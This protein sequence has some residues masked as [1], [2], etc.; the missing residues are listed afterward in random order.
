MNKKTKIINVLYLIWTYND[1]IGGHYQSFIST[2]NSVVDSKINVHIINIGHKPALSLEKCKYK[3]NYIKVT[4]ETFPIIKKR[5]KKYSTSNNIDIIHS[6]DYH[7]Y[8]FTSTTNCKNIVTYPGGSNY[9]FFPKADNILMFS[10][11]NY[12]YFSQ[13]KKYTN[14]F[15]FL[16]QNRVNEVEQD[17]KKIEEL[18][19]KYKP[20][21]IKI[22]KIARIGP[23]YEHSIL[24]AIDFSNT[25]SS[26]N[27]E[28]T[29]YIIGFIENINTKITIQRKIQNSKNKNIHLIDNIRYTNNAN[30]LIDLC[31]LILATGRGIMEGMALKKVVLAPIDKGYDH[32]LVNNENIDILEYYNFSERS[33]LSSTDV[34]RHSQQLDNLLVNN[35]HLNEYQ[36]WARDTFENRYSTLNITEKL[37]KIYDSISP[38]NKKLKFDYK[39]NYQ[40]IK[41]LVLNKLKNLG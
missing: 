9:K 21:G 26:K 27:I 29:L 30:S 20:N 35:A 3:V 7:S 24:S 8:F 36:T 13:L 18:L 41:F 5:I 1:G 31:D 25:L 37:L 11:E 12:N 32:T 23:Y 2:I 14:S 17:C 34:L 40:V 19:L 33:V 22:L 39:F 16:L 28:N 38:S 10:K 6:Y 15:F 4:I